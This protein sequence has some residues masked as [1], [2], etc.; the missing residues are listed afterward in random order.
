VGSRRSE[1]DIAFG[2]LTAELRYGPAESLGDLLAKR[3]YT[4]LRCGGCRHV[5]VLHPAVMA[6]IV[7][8]DCR[9]ADLR[10]RLN[11]RNAGGSG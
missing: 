2:L 9:L 4:L 6:R 10:C 1:R 7:G 3:E 5:A 11:A 8:H